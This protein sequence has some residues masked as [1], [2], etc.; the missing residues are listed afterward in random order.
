M[1][2]R[3][4]MHYIRT[5]GE[6]FQAIQSWWCEIQCVVAV[7]TDSPHKWAEIGLE[8]QQVSVR[9]FCLILIYWHASVGLWYPHGMQ[10]RVCLEVNKVNQKKKKKCSLTRYLGMSN[11]LSILNFVSLLNESKWYKVNWRL[12]IFTD[13]IQF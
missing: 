10:N 6:W 7:I 9:Y 13:Y 12:I 5:L 11:L 1:F 3:L 2:C 8:G 4:Y